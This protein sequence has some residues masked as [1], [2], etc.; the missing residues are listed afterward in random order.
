MV[1]VK[2]GVQFKGR[3]RAKDMMLVLGLNETK[4]QLAMANS[5]HW[6]GHVLTVW[7]CLENGIRL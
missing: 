2:C 3:K 4:D 6:H 5:I 1:R 7:P